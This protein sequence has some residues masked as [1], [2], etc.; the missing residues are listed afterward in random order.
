MSK[1]NWDCIGYLLL[2]CMIGQENS[3]HLVQPIR[4][5]FKT[6]RGT[7]FSRASGYLL[8]LDSSSHW[9]P[10]TFSFLLTGRP[11]HFELGFTAF[12]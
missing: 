3:R 7:A 1:V 6:N 11:D 5:K 2:H 12:N 10:L 9:F 8:V 4:Y